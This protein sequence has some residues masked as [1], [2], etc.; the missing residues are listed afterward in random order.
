MHE[1]S[2]PTASP[3]SF[4]LPVALAV[5]VGG[6][7]AGLLL[8][9]IDKAL[10][11]GDRVVAVDA[12]VPVAVAPPGG[13]DMGAPVAT[14]VPPGRAHAQPGAGA[15]PRA[16]AL[17]APAASTDVATPVVAPAAAPSFEPAAPMPTLPG[18]IAA[19]RE[20]ASEACINGTIARR[21]PHGWQQRLDNDAPVACIERAVAP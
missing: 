3:W 2:H 8:R 21:D 17:P 13:A 14:P 5:L 1:Y 19:R 15:P 9:G 10:R 12:I 16:S 20:G 4:F 6:L 18:A 11:S 7:V